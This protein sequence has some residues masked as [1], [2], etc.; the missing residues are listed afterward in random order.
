MATNICSQAT[1]PINIDTNNKAEDCKLKCNY[2]YDYPSSI[3]NIANKGNYLQIDYTKS[4][5]SPVTYNNYELVVSDFRIYAPSLHTYDGV[6][7]DG[8]I[9]ISHSGTLNLLV[10]IPLVIS[11]TNNSA[12]KN[13]KDIIT[14]AAKQTPTIGESASL[15]INNFTINNFIPSK[16]F[17]V[18]N[19]TLPYSPCSGN[20]TIM[21]F[22]KNKV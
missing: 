1:A 7:A 17:Y 18:Y 15:N 19:A 16:E 9:I 14:L 13:L 8:E 22:Q 11:S 5:N 6:H 4:G 3:C 21:V 20:N 2:I 12:Q 10:C